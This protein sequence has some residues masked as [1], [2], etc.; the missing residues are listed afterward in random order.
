MSIEGKKWF[1]LVFLSMLL[2][3]STSIG[4]LHTDTAGEEDP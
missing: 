4:L 3:I 2:L 1:N